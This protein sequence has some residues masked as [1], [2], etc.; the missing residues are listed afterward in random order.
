M[1]SDRASRPAGMLFS[2][3]DIRLQP[4]GEYSTALQKI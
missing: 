3:A 4:D 1:V 2:L